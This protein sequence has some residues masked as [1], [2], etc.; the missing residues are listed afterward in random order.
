MTVSVNVEVARQAG[1]LVL[2]A[3]AVR[4]AGKEAWVMVVRA[5]RAVRQPVKLGIRGEG[6]VQ[7]LDGLAEGEAVLLPSAGVAPGARVRPRPDA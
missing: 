4:D 3:D 1:A 7:V 5:G 6:R 2:P